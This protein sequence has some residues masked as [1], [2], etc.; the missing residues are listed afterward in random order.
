MYIGEVGGSL[1]EMRK[2][3]KNTQDRMLWSVMI[4]Y[5]L[6]GR[7]TLNNDNNNSKKHH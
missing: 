5:V 2:T 6:K 3:A 1:S 7:G 4:T